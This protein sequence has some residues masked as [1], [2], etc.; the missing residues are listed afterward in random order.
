MR[1]RSFEPWWRGAVALLILIGAAGCMSCAAPAPPPSPRVASAPTPPEGLEYVPPPPGSYRL[2]PI[3]PAVDGAVL[4]T[5][6]APR[7][8]FDYV[9]EDRYVLLSFIYT[10]CTDSEGCPLAT[11]VLEMVRDALAAEPELARRVRLVTLSFDPQRDTPAALRRYARH[12][13]LPDPARP[14]GD[15]PWV[16]L[17]TASKDALQP[18]LEG[19]G[20]SVVREFDADGKPTGDFS[21]VLKVFLIDRR[22]RVRN[23]YSTSF[24]HPAIAINDLKTLWMEDGG[25]G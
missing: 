4:D 18:I 8:L 16:F 19:Y 22:R 7:R 15:R 11:G 25:P 21:H 12:A 13:G 3:E 23:I 20:Q 9:G 1:R 2:P 10:R 5:G 14:E 24:L 17:T 6:G